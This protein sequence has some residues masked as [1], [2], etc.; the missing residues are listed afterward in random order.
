V[1]RGGWHEFE[2]PLVLSESAWIAARAF[3]LSPLGTPDAEA[4][5]NP[6]YVDVD[7]KEPFR[8]E[9]FDVLLGAIDR[10]IAIHGRRHFEQQA[11]ILAYFHRAREKLLQLR[12]SGPARSVDAGR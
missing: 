2:Y 8:R 1:G 4:H 12:E 7:G 6:V 3:S 10:Q 5:T 9:S 11:E